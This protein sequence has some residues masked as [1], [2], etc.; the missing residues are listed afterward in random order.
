MYLLCFLFLGCVFL[1][2]EMSGNQI[3]LPN[4]SLGEVNLATANS[5]QT[6]SWDW[7]RTGDSWNNNRLQHIIQELMRLVIVIDLM[8]LISFLFILSL[9]LFF[10]CSPTLADGLTITWHV[11][12]VRPVASR[13]V[14]SHQKWL[15]F[16][17]PQ[18]F[19]ISQNWI[20]AL[21]TNWHLVHGLQPK[22]LQLVNEQCPCR[23]C[24]INREIEALNIK[25]A[26]LAFLLL[27]NSL[28]S[29]EAKY[30]M[31]VFAL[32]KSLDLRKL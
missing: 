5:L 19:L 9:S 22:T 31:I 30:C 10:S 8:L 13:Q 1:A 3:R 2:R 18:S 4:S 7:W 28:M 6:G 32:V 29:F 12:T 16:Y 24:D 20:Y 23:R 27:C 17:S 25:A 26:V 11:P 21:R 14:S 15:G